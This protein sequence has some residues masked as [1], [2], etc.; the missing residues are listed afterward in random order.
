MKQRNQISQSSKEEKLIDAK[1]KYYDEETDEI[2]HLGLLAFL[3]TVIL[4]INTYEDLIPDDY[5]R[6][7]SNILLLGGVGLTG[8][9]YWLNRKKMQTSAKEINEI[10][11][12]ALEN[13]INEPAILRNLDIILKQRED[14]LYE[15]KSLSGTWIDKLVTSALSIFTLG[16]YASVGY[17]ED[18]N[19]KV[20]LATLST[21]F[22][23]GAGSTSFLLLKNRRK[24][25][26]IWNKLTELEDRFEE[27][28][29]QVRTIK[30]K[31]IPGGRVTLRTVQEKKDRIQSIS[32]EGTTSIQ[33]PSASPLTKKDTENASQKSKNPS[34]ENQN[35]S[36]D[37]STSTKENDLV[38]APSSSTK[39]TIEKEAVT[40]SPNI[41]AV[42]STPKGTSL[43][44]MHTV[45]KISEDV[46]AQSGDS[47]FASPLPNNLA[48]E[49]KKEPRTTTIPPL[50]PQ[51]P[52]K[53]EVIPLPSESVIS[54]NFRPNEAGW[55]RTQRK[56]NIARK[57]HKNKS[58]HRNYTDTQTLT[59]LCFFHEPDPTTQ[60]KQT[61]F[62]RDQ[63]ISSP[64]KQE[65]QVKKQIKKTAAPKKHRDPL[66][67]LEGVHFFDEINPT[68]QSNK[69]LTQDKKGFTKAPLP[70]QIEPPEI[71]AELYPQTKNLD[72][73]I[74]A[75]Q[76]S[77]ESTIES[78]T[79]SLLSA[80]STQ[81]NTTDIPPPSCEP[82]PLQLSDIKK[83][84]DDEQQ[85]P[86]RKNLNLRETAMQNLSIVSAL[87]SVRQELNNTKEELADLSRDIK[88]TT[89]TLSQNFQPLHDEIN[90]LDKKFNS[91]DK[92]LIPKRFSLTDL[93]DIATPKVRR[94]FAE[95]IILKAELEKLGATMY[96]H[97]SFDAK[98]C[99][100]LLTGKKLKAKDIDIVVELPPGLSIDGLLKKVP[101]STRDFSFKKVSTDF[102]PN[103][104]IPQYCNFVSNDTNCKKIDLVVR[105]AG[106][107]PN[108]DPFDATNHHTNFTSKE[109]DYGQKEIYF[110]PEE[111]NLMELSANILN[112]IFSA[113]LHNPLYAN[114][115]ANFIPRLAKYLVRHENKMEVTGY[116]FTLTGQKVHLSPEDFQREMINYFRNAL[117]IEMSE[118]YQ[119]AFFGMKKMIKEGHFTHAAVRNLILSFCAGLLAVKQKLPHHVNDLGMIAYEDV[120]ED[121]YTYAN[122]MTTIL[123]SYFK[124]NPQ[125]SKYFQLITR[126][127]LSEAA[128]KIWDAFNNHEI[129]AGVKL[130]K[131]LL[132]QQFPDSSKHSP[133]PPGERTLTSIGDKDPLDFNSPTTDIKLKKDA[134]SASLPG[135]NLYSNFNTRNTQKKQVETFISTQTP[136][137]SPTSMPK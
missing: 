88:Q 25:T 57:K 96:L 129:T 62:V 48:Q 94:A 84:K 109:D 8:F 127:L 87:Q 3:S 44:N 90:L 9:S 28:N 112:G 137:V 27:L 97:G 23:G 5:H 131:E 132:N 117:A 35:S 74:I 130:L 18:F 83:P 7:M 69:T 80:F 120:S 2:T 15:F 24:R 38:P 20:I 136:A 106:Y 51:N 47:I 72:E 71:R 105:E 111:S 118:S 4:N 55:N 77:G 108:F 81:T 95:L 40:P 99:T 101:L 113:Q 92:N 45:P 124:E 114:N 14:L 125:D 68:S 34:G 82:N 37:K 107:T 75:E 89:Q 98:C 104:N 19:N 67:A 60:K 46:Q 53:S 66:D 6:M 122:Q 59:G 31:E 102:I 133:P 56:D 65:N 85:I 73:S 103:P 11:R 70:Q 12:I 121:I 32:P 39:Q 63:K 22:A 58:S 86:T 61:K 16:S 119:H 126:I 116:F 110:F 42:P 64:K 91:F 50:S 26:D 76:T 115:I 134:K 17:P 36:S 13:R 93:S 29:H 1:N 30:R 128:A 78:T 33:K 123:Q 54:H 10:D 100:Y 49:E 79:N 21:L 52:K 41:T 43:P 135:N